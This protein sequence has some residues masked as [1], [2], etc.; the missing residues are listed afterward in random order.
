M[1][2]APH[3]ERRESGAS[4]GPSRASH[5]HTWLLLW[6]V[7]VGGLAPDASEADVHRALSDLGGVPLLSLRL[8]VGV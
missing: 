8:Q 5:A 1:E 3:A 4:A 6:Q 7:F 2:S